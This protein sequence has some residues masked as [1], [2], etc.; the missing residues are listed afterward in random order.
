MSESEDSRPPIGQVTAASRWRVEVVEETTSTNAA[1]AER[2]RA[3]EGEGLVL[4]AEHQTAG[5]G[6]LGRD[7]VSPPRSSLTVSFL[8]APSDVAPAR[9]PWLP[10][11]T[12]IAAAAAVRRITGVQ[13]DLKWP[14][15]VLADGQKLG[16]ILL[17]RVEQAGRAAAVVGI[18][19]NCAQ[20]GDELPVPQAT[21]LAI[22]TGARVDRSALLTALLEELAARYDEWRSG[23]D[24]RPAYLELCSTPGLQVKVAVPGGEVTGE[25]VDVDAG[26]RLVVRTETGEEHLGVGDVV[27]VRPQ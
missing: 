4:V 17:E 22:V 23:V 10:L 20:S 12:G 15:D 16:G 18:G 24:L 6:R 9:W 26:G 1:V 14:N 7:W 11:L 8:L 25:A 19:L 27:H 2:F 13:V 3:G 21:S 5:R